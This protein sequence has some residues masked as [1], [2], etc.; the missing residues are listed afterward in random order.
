M[1]PYCKAFYVTYN[2]INLQYFFKQNS[3]KA[4][5]RDLKNVLSEQGFVCTSTDLQLSQAIHFYAADEFLHILFFSP[6]L[7]F[8]EHLFSQSLYFSKCIPHQIFPALVIPSL[9]LSVRADQTGTFQVLLME[10]TV[11]NQLRIVK[12]HFSTSLPMGKSPALP[13]VQSTYFHP[14]PVY[15]SIF[16]LLSLFPHC[17]SSRT[18][19][20]SLDFSKNYDLQSMDVEVDYIHFNTI[21]LKAGIIL[22]TL[23]AEMSS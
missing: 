11:G 21:K 10:E 19:L 2:C 3:F 7:F 6:F 20:I 15:V 14:F 16:T 9:H 1:H 23:S 4:E 18:L 22:T 12:N 13:D 17:C 5:S 8:F